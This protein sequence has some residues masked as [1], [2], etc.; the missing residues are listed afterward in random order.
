MLHIW[1]S[2]LGRRVFDEHDETAL[3]RRASEG[4][5]T[6]I[7]RWRV[8]V[9]GACLAKRVEKVPEHNARKI[10]TLVSSTQT[11]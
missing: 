7:P 6:L 1:L 4:R 8:G 2:V 10:K 3:T 9:V 5:L 11:G